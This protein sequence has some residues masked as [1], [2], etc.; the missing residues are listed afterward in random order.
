MSLLKEKA[1]EVKEEFD[2][3]LKGRG[4][5]LEAALPL[6]V[7]LILSSFW[8]ADV[9]SGAAVLVAL[10]YV[11]RDL[12]KGKLP[13]YSLGGFTALLAGLAAFRFSGRT[14]D[15]LLSSLLSNLLLLGLCLLSVLAKR[16]LVAW[17]SYLARHYPL[18]WYW[19]SRIRPA[20]SEVTLLWGLFF[21][22]RF[23]LQVMFLSSGRE[24][25]LFAFSI[26]SGWPAILVLLVV[27]YLYGIW[28]LRKLHGP[29]AEEFRRGDPPPWK[30][31]QRGF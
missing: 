18:S 11:A 28:R 14:G 16:P 24:T 23:L 4:H 3:V 27:S 5:F 6:L 26:L 29:S 8:R 21:G 20:Y 12:R 22:A 19:H 31:Q 30:G 13:V 9:A 17:T 7:F 10:F 2:Q 25:A 1:R 15:V